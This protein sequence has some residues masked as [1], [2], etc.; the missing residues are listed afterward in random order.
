MTTTVPNS[1]PT[2]VACA[3]LIGTSIEWYDFY[4]YGTAAALVF[5]T[6]FFPRFDPAVGTLL[7]LA[8]FGVGTVARPIGGFV[9]GHFGDRLGRKNM[10]VVALL[11]MG[12]ATVL[13]GLL[14]TYAAIG[15]WAPILLVTLRTAQGFALGGEWGG[16]VLM[17]V[18]HAPRNRRAFLGSWPQVGSSVGLV[19][20]TAVFALVSLLPDAQ[21]GAWGWRVPF[22]LSTVLVVVGLLIRA[23]LPESPEFTEV[24]RQQRRVAR[25]LVEVVTGSPR[26]VLSGIAAIAG[27]IVAFYVVTVFGPSYA[28]S[29]IGYGRTEILVGVMIAAVTEAVA[30]LLAARTAD[31]IGPRPVG[32]VGAIAVVAATF[33]FFLAL[34]SGNIALAWL[35]MA[36]IGFAVGIVYGIVPI[37][38]SMLFPTHLRYSG[39]SMS[40]AVAAGVIGGLSPL[41]AAAL[42]GATGSYWPIAL[43]VVVISALGLAGFTAGATASSEPRSTVAG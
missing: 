2:R 13:I 28:T 5:N 36:V 43:Y 39:S 16:A 4:I 18:E 31:R 19:L 24:E 35:M 30:V 11:M 37:Y 33:P 9:F 34:N 6:A 10:L 27:S 17:A 42:H 14:P 40:Y 23:R 7:A 38:V 21:F 41:V 15:V 3:S 8:T 32:I 20:G 22:L 12:V 26:Q 1:S 25:P 29:A